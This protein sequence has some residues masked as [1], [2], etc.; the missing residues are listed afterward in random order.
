MS[1]LDCETDSTGD[2]GFAIYDLPLLVG[3]VADGGKTITLAFANAGG[4]DSRWAKRPTAGTRFRFYVAATGTIEEGLV[5]NQTSSTMTTEAWTALRNQLV[6][7][8]TPASMFN[9]PFV[10]QLQSSVNAAP[11]DEARL[12]DDPHE[13]VLRGCRVRNSGSRGIVANTSRIRLENNQIEDTLSPAVH[14]MAF[15]KEGGP[16]FHDDISI[17]SN[18]ITRGNLSRSTSSDFLGSICVS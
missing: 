4:T 1:I 6:A 9:E 16:G 10:V 3:A 2:D 11:G 8:T 5:T 18:P 15:T 7:A 12:L 13:T 17:R 14:I